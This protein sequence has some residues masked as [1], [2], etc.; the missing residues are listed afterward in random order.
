MNRTIT[1]YFILLVEP[2]YLKHKLFLCVDIAA[3]SLSH[4]QD[5]RWGYLALELITADRQFF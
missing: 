1:A 2:V 5:V 3:F 4:L